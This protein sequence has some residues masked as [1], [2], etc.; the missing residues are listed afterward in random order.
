MRATYIL[1]T[2]LVLCATLLCAGL[3]APPTCSEDIK[4]IHP[5][6][7]VT[8]LA[9]VIGADKTTTLEALCTELEQKTGAQ[10]EIVTVRS[11]EGQSIEYYAVDL[12]RFLGIGS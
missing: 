5:T 1:R 3:S 2:S 6:G 7:Y 10:M 4:S 8:D 9:G 12:F 11:L